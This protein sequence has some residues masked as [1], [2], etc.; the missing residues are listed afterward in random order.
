M[1]E[2]YQEETEST[3]SKITSQESGN[4]NSQRKKKDFPHIK[5]GR[6]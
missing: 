3:T 5:Q 1:Q 4:A 6:I 2:E